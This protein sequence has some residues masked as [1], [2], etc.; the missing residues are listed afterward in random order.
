MV[1]S[2]F[3]NISDPVAWNLR[4]RWVNIR[5]LLNE[6]NCIVTHI[7]RECNKVAD[8]LACHGLSLNSISHWNVALVFIRDSLAKNHL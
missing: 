4:N 1:V 2:A 5:I 6:M 7:H 3:N 8:L